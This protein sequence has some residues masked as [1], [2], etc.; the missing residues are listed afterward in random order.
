MKKYSVLT[1]IMNNYDLV[2]EPF[3]ISDDA[4]YVLV[5][6]NPNLKSNKWQ[7]KLIPD[8]LKNADGFTK[9]FYVRYHPFEFVNTDIC[10][11]L[12]GSIQIKKSLDK[13]YN[14]F[15]KSNNDCLFMVH[16]CQIN[17]INEYGYWVTQRNYPKEQVNKTF[18]FFKAI[19]YDK[20][21]KG[22]FEATF[23]IV[24]KCSSIENLHNF[25]YK[26]LEK[27]G[28]DNL[29]IERVDQGILTAVINTNFTDLK[30]LPATHQ[31]I[32]NNYMTYCHHNTNKSYPV[33]VDYKNL[34]LF[35]KPVKVYTLE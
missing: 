3:E 16:Y 28:V 14:D 2:R 8:W 18:A 7:I 21:Y 5:T 29:H 31:I 15:I 23:K 13:L 11:V 30:I 9:S 33:K 27:I 34:Y 10:M 4:E 24:K 32:Q 22:S 6:D 20:S 1:F 25:V 12:D 35:N 26:C 19:G 17:I